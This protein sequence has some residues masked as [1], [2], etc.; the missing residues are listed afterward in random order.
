MENNLENAKK[1][2]EKF[3]NFDA[4]TEEDSDLEFLI[5]SAMVDYVEQL[6]L[7]KPAV[8]NQRELLIAFQSWQL[9]KGYLNNNSII[10]EMV[11]AYLKSN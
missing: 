11:D 9:E 5:L 2:A 7:N 6:K 3:I 10:N 4:F 1:I 8:S